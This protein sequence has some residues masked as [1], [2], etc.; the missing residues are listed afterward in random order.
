MSSAGEPSGIGSHKGSGVYTGDTQFSKGCHLSEA[1]FAAG[2]A[3]LVGEGWLGGGLGWAGCLLDQV[4]C[5]HGIL[6]GLR[7]VHSLLNG[8]GC[9]WPCPL[10]P[11]TNENLAGE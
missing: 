1:C 5:H 7:T 4:L 2:A 3:A 9:C 6:V 8:P 10:H 11:E